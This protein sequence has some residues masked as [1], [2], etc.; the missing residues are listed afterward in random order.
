MLK[1][2]MFAT[3]ALMFATM[4]AAPSKASAQVVFRVGVGPVAVVAPAP[5]P[6]VVAAPYPYVAPGYVYPQVVVG[7]RWY[8]RGYVYRGYVP[9]YGWRR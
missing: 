8:P 1:K 7:A 9:R 6:V 2:A 5:A 3:V 4:L